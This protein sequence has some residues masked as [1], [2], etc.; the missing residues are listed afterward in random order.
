MGPALRGQPLPGLSRPA[1]VPAAQQSAAD[2]LDQLVQ[3]RL[4][5]LVPVHQAVGGVEVG[6]EVLGQPV[7]VNVFL[8]AVDQL[9]VLPK[10]QIRVE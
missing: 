5:G 4:A 2:D 8:A 3:Y 10:R 1:G 9:S 7:Q 6:L